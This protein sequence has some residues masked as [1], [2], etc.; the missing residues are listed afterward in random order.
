MKHSLIIIVV[1]IIFILGISS[2]WVYNAL[3]KQSQALSKDEISNLQLSFVKYYGTEANITE[4][5]IPKIY[6]V[7]W[8]D[9]DGNKNVSMNVGGVW[10]LIASVPKGE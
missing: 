8:T 6:E 2:G 5:I 10:V 3:Q 1:S 9:K 7:A 4:G